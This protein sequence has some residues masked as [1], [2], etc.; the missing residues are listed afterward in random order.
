MKL[1]VRPAARAG[2]MLALIALSVAQAGAE[3]GSATRSWT[4]DGL[5]PGQLPAEFVV[6]TLYDGRPAGE[7]KVLQTDRAK[8]PPHVLGQL[9]G[10]GAEHAYK[11]VLIN[12]TGAS[13]IDLQV[14]FLP[15]EG[16]ADMGGGL[17]WRATDDRNYYLTRAN[18]LEQNIRIYRVSKG[19]R[20]LLLNFDQII[21][22]KQWHTLHVITRGDRIQVLYDEKP[23][24]D[25]RDETFKEGK[26]GL[27][28]KSDA[29]TYFDD[30]QF[31]MLK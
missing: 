27:W 31:Q 2:W 6:G 7:W 18:P 30:L 19:V 9:A 12:G 23:V 4:F 21:D 8:S 26:I 28:T 25:L 3:N 11:T 17:I 24:F 29:I 22:V 10:K 15:I 13:D 1:I 5:A 16:K 14:S 20:H